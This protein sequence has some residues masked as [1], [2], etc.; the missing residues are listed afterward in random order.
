MPEQYKTTDGR[1][2]KVSDGEWWDTTSTDIVPEVVVD[3]YM[4]RNSVGI[5][6]VELAEGE[7][8]DYLTPWGQSVRPKLH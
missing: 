1:F 6:V 8:S 2:V 4:R 3:D 5:M 7:A